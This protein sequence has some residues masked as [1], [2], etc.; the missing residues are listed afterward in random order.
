MRG[1]IKVTEYIGPLQKL[2]L[3][4]ANLKVLAAD[5]IIVEAVSLSCTSLTR[6]V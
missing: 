4:D 2:V 3:L 5:E 6:R 1:P